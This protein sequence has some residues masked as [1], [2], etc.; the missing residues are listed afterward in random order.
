MAALIIVMTVM[1]GFRAEL[2]DRILG[3]N[4]HLYV[5]G[6]RAATSPTATPS[7]RRMPSVPGVVQRHAP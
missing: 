4:G 3:F 7:W 1:N 2:L 5:A 6:R